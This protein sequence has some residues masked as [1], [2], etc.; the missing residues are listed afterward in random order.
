MIKRASQIKGSGIIS[1]IYNKVGEGQAFV[2]NIPKGFRSAVILNTDKVLSYTEKALMWCYKY[3][4]KLMY[5]DGVNTTNANNFYKTGIID[6]GVYFDEGNSTL[7][8]QLN[9]NIFTLAD[10]IINI[11]TTIRDGNIPTIVAYGGGNDSYRNNLYTRFLSGRN[12]RH[13]NNTRP[14]P[15]LGGRDATDN[16]TMEYRYLK[17]E[18]LIS[19]PCTNRYDYYKK[20]SSFANPQS[21][22][23]SGFD[24]QGDKDYLNKIN[25]V[26]NTNNIYTVFGHVYWIFGDGFKQFLLTVDS[27]ISGKSFYKAQWGEIMEYW[28][29]KDSIDTFNFNPDS[30]VVDITYSKRDVTRP[31]VN[32]KT[33]L[34]IDINLKGTSL[35]GAFIQTSVASEIIQKSTDVYSIGIMLD[36]TL[37]SKSFTISSAANANHYSNQNIPVVTVNTTTKLITSDQPIKY[38][39]FSKLKAQSEA[40]VSVIEEFM[41]ALNASPTI[42]VTLNTATKDYYLGFVNAFG[43]SGLIT[44]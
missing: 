29:V 24:L 10:P 25:R 41:H 37:T 5:N 26:Y 44:F 11:I 9:N 4:Y 12:S 16:D 39:L 43:I 15:I 33:P 2:S 17:K 1:S 31:Y 36:F 18:K 35:Q 6:F 7:I 32:I 30:L 21:E 13:A 14:A 22:F 42:G 20:V 23:S 3:G 34:W 40:D 19:R 28:Y 38:T 27:A 8:T